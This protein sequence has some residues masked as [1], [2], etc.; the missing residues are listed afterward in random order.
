MS[1]K[2]AAGRLFLA[3]LEGLADCVLRD[4]LT[5]LGGYSGAVTEFVRVSGSVLPERTFRRISPELAKGYAAWRLLGGVE[6]AFDFFVL[7]NCGL[8]STKLTIFLALA[9]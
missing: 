1:N 9:R 8:C 4:V 3:P 6:L 2:Q 7:H 5:R